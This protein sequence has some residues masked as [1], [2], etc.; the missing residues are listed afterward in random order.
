MSDNVLK[1]DDELLKKRLIELSETSYRKNIPVHTD[2]LNLYEQ[3]IFHT[4]RFSTCYRVYGGYELSER[5]IV[6][7]IPYEDYPYEEP[8]SIIK[9]T[10]VNAKFSGDLT[11]RDFLGTVLGLG[12]DR[13]KIGDII[14]TNNNAYIFC[15][16]SMTDY[17]VNNL[18]RIK[19]TP[20]LVS[21]SDSVPED[22]SANY[23][24]IT[25]SISSVRLDSILALAFNIS[26][27]KIITNIEE[28]LVFVN[29]RL[30]TTNSYTLKEDDIISVRHMGRFMYKGTI[31]TS[32]KGRYFVKLHK[33]I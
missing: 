10:P 3:S 13:S 23:K 22:I 4:V 2:F 8:I 14:V 18:T 1:K 21:L 31:G 15:I 7:F 25:G 6:S 32:K 33:Y 11:H 26:R 28:G 19:H 24:E 9:V 5:K 20:V 16:S 17:I 12:I 27:S 30:I 29:G